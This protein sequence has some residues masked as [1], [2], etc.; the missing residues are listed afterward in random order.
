MLPIAKKSALVLVLVIIASLVFPSVV[1][2]DGGPIVPHDLWGELTEGQQT[3][4]VTIV[5]DNTAKIDLFVSILDQTQQSHDITYF[6]PLGTTSSSFLAIEQEL[7]DFDKNNTNGLDKLLRDDANGKQVAM[8]ILFSGTLLSNGGILVPLWTPLLLSACGAAQQK[9]D[10]TYQTASSQISIYSINTDTDIKELIAVTGLAASVQDTLNRLQGQQIAVVKMKT[11][12]QQPVSGGGRPLGTVSEPG[13]HLSWISKLV[14]TPAGPAYTY[15]LGTGGAWSKPIN[16]TR[17]YI[18]APNRDFKV[19]Y[20]ALGTEQSGFDYVEGAKISKYYDIPAYAVDEARGSFGR[21]MRITYSMSNPTSDVTV[22][23]SPLTGGSKFQNSIASH[24]SM[25]A[26]FFA[27]I[28]GLGF[29]FLSWRFLMPRFLGNPSAPNLQW[30]MALIYPVVSFVM[31]FIPGGIF[32]I[33]YILGAPYP[34]LALLFIVQA[35]VSIGLFE[36]IHGGKLGVSR[37]IATRSFVYVSLVSSGAYLVLA[38][39]LSF[40]LGLV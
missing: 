25:I 19:D 1:K 5:D 3:A 40:I 30:Y 20:P 27:I 31:M 35:G 29:W 7:F 21:V 12:V 2:A 26:F 38:T 6:V 17:V 15:P 8:Q 36:L 34:A 33:V 23:T 10:A 22:V 16:L 14:S 18:V 9:P 11:R 4:I 13:L 37:G 39:A 32:W 28:I 24:R